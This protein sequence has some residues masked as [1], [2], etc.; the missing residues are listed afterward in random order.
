MSKKAISYTFVFN[1]KNKL[2]SKGHA[3]IEIYLN[4][5]GEK[6]YRSTGIQI[7]P[8]QWND[9][10]KYIVK[11]TSYIELNNRLKEIQNSYIETETN[12]GK[13]NGTNNCSV[14]ELI[15]E[16]DKKLESKFFYE[17]AKSQINKEHLSN[18]RQKKLEQYLLEFKK[19]SDDVLLTRIDSS[20]IEDYMNYLRKKETNRGIGNKENY[21]T[22]KLQPVKKYVER[23][24]RDG[25]IQQTKNPFYDI[26]FKNERTNRNALS[27]E[28]IQQLEKIKF[29]KANKNYERIRDMFL[30]QFYTG[31]AF[32]D[33]SQLTKNDITETKQGLL[34][35][36]KNRQKTDKPMFLP[37]YAMFK[38][39]GKESKPEQL[40]RKYWSKKE[41]PFF[42]LPNGKDDKANNQYVNR[43]LKTKIIPLTTI[44]KHVTTHVARHS[45]ATY[46]I[47]KMPVPIVSNLLQHSKIETTMIYVH[48]S[49]ENIIKELNKIENWD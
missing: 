32:I 17:Y 30:F 5:D 24:I 14:K 29:D 12:I 20:L 15:A 8:K 41:T 7:E 6:S 27:L 49:N 44:K 22:K 36:T 31:M 26:K 39:M 1:R 28:D 37:L 4:K 48:V 10:K 43:I 19:F 9:D 42:A 33:A 45:F 25:I 3:P 18:D 34:I 21:I 13:Q 23:A 40:L 38:V 11:H 46:M 2:N 35:D 16:L 47:W